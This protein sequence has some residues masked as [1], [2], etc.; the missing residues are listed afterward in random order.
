MATSNPEPTSTLKCVTT[1][2]RLQK[3][4]S[5]N[6]KTKN[7]HSRIFF[8]CILCKHGSFLSGHGVWGLRKMP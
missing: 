6:W 1:D 8:E 3:L 2:V 7:I 4:F 5:G